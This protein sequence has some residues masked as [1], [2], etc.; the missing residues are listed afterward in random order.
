MRHTITQL[1]RVKDALR[2]G[3]AEK[4]AIRG[5]MQAMDSGRSD[6]YEVLQAEAMIA[7]LQMVIDDLRFAIKADRMR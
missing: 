2:A 1:Q 4:F 7:Y 3:E 5:A 6:G